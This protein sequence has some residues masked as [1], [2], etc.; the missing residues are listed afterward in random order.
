[1]AIMTTAAIPDGRGDLVPG[2]GATFSAAPSRVPQHGAA[3]VAVS[4]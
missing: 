2:A 3:K 4:I 1:M